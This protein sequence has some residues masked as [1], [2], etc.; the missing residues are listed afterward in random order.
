MRW[1]VAEYQPVAL[2]SL[3]HG[4]ATSTGGKSLL[5]P[6]PFS[7]RM[8]LLDAAIRTMRLGP[9]HSNW[10]DTV[11]KIR[12]LTLAVNP[13]KHAAVTNL[14]VAHTG[15]LQV[16]DQRLVDAGTQIEKQR[17]FGGRDASARV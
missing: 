2:F 8:A 9:E 1:L 12:S 15:R 16:L 6:T 7:I 13:P 3:K 14:F 11:E 5:L 4:E 10:N 17:A